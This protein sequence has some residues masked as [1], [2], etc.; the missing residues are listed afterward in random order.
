MQ[1]SK[2]DIPVIYFHSVAPSKN[3]KWFRNFLTMELELFEQFLIYLRKNSYETIFFDDYYSIRRGEIR[4][5]GNVCLLTFDDG[6]VDNYI[7]VWPLLKRYG[8]RGT[9]FVN[10]ENVDTL[11]NTALTIEDA[12][13]GRVT[14]KEIEKWGYLS[15]NEMKIMFDSGVIDI[16][17][18]TMTHTKYF[19]SDKLIDFHH[20]GYDC[21]YPVANLF[22]SRKPYYIN[23]P[24]FEKLLPY[25]Y[26]I[27]EEKSAVIAKRVDLNPEFI[28]DCTRMLNDYDFKNYRFND[29]FSRIRSLYEKFKKE[30][31]LIIRSENE[32]EYHQ[33]VRMEISESKKIIEKNLNKRVNILCWPHGD[34]SEF[35]HATALEEGYIMTTK[36]NMPGIRPDDLSRI[37]ER[38]GVNFST[39]CKRIKTKIKMRAFSGKYPYNQAIK[40]SRKLRD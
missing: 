33:R 34:N 25:G 8:F 9:I 26:P 38:I 37:G 17:S 14:L 21:L 32:D 28:D 22:P 18:H 24:E 36:G 11:R 5:P 30:G 40:L 23:D 27:F 15:W 31:T 12:E 19:V 20:P 1:N 29:A 35:C 3:Q 39:V 2:T 4:Y 10:P 6:Y 16:Q 7:Y 13:S